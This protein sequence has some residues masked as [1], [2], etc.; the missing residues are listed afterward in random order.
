MKL[1]MTQINGKI[2]CSWVKIINI[3][4]IN[5]LPKEIYRFKKIHI[6]IPMPFFRKVIKNNPKTGM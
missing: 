4:K 5:I 2:L 1:K 3:V 6:I